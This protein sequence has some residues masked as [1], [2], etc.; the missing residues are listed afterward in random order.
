M[1]IETD[2]EWE[3]ITMEIQ[4]RK[5]G[6]YNEWYIGLYKSVI[7]GN[8]TW[9]NGKALTIDKW[10]GNTPNDNKSYTLMAKEWPTG[11]KGSFKSITGNI[12]RGWI[13]EEI[14][15]INKV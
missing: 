2:R 6:K 13:C 3:F 14:T 12:S 8:W 5:S 15:G 4:T 10:Q 1:V 11:F 7:T 9:I